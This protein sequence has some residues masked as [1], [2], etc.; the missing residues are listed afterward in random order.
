MFFNAAIGYKYKMSGLQAALGLAQLERIDELV[1][2]KREIFS[3][4]QKELA[5]VSGITLNSEASGTKNTYWMITLILDEKFGLQKKQLMD[6]LAKQNIDS[7]PFFHPLSAI[8]AYENSEQAR[9][10]RKRNVNSHR[11][12]PWGINLPSALNLTEQKV[13]FV[14]DVLKNILRK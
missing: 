7:R 14:C 10:A 11:I 9:L 13:K 1:A 6:L 4:Y 8:P 12:S 2:R 5:G 3:W